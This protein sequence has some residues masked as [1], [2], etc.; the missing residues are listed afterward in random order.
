M[1]VP[2]PTARHPDRARLV[3]REAELEML[4]AALRDCAAGRPEVALISGEPGVG[5]TRLMA[6]VAARAG[7][8]LGA[9]TLTGFAVESGGMPAYFPLS[10]ALRAAVTPLAS[11]DPSSA[12]AASVLAEA[13]MVA[14]DFD[15][16]APPAPLPPEAERLR[17]F[18]ACT[19]LCLLLA[20]R[21]RLLLALDDLQW[22][23]R[24][25]WD[26]LI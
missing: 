5:K 22:A 16:F 2:V 9:R 15:G 23:D 4:L 20:K 10:R 11:A 25:T 12:R 14:A 3:G 6:E 21:Q 17:L 13:G 26:M 18:D 24:G 8:E 19:E 1:S 7:P